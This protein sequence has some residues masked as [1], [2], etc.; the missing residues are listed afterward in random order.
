MNEVGFEY[1]AC[2]QRK[3]GVLILSEFA[4]APLEQYRRGGWMGSTGGV[5]KGG[6]ERGRFGFEYVARQTLKHGVLILSEFAGATPITLPPPP[7]FPLDI[8]G[9]GHRAASRDDYGW[10]IGGRRGRREGGAS[11]WG[12]SFPL[13]GTVMFPFH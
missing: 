12:S 2:Q 9:G 6:E 5:R 1:V 3:H 8:A 7:R 13:N 4:G 11:G 10:D